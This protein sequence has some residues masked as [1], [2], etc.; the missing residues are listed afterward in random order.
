MSTSKVVA[1]HFWSPTCTPCKLIAPTIE[2][3]K[4]EFDTV[5]WVSTNTTEDTDN[6][7]RTLKVVAVPTIVVLK[8][9]YEV[10]RHSG[11]SI[12]GYYTLFRRATIKDS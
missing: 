3:L 10:G 12:I 8:G 6:L 5:T 9:G 11:T 7:A 1:C 4:E 2:N